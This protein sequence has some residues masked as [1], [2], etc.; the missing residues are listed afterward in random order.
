MTSMLAAN[1]APS[2]ESMFAEL[3]ELEPDSPEF[4]RGRDRIIEHTLSIADHVARRFDGRGEL[5]DDLV[6]V[7]RVGLINAVIRFDVRAGSDFV[8]FAVPTITG[9]IRHHFRDRSWSVKVPRRYK[10]LYPRLDAATSVL[11]QR[12]GR[13]PT[14]SEVADE[15]GLDRAEVVEGLV[16]VSAY[17]ILSIDGA[18]D[19]E[20][21]MAIR[22]FGESD[23]NLDGIE[24]R[25][26]LRT[27][28]ATLPDRERTVLVLR[29]F[30]SLSQSQIADRIG[31]SQMQVSRLL[32][33]SLGQLRDQVA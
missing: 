20:V 15:L 21:P 6:Q 16:A 23:P 22:G 29:F 18:A 17:N 32:A 24:N 27:L 11:S 5:R 13:A 30:G 7:A 25:E 3:A 10:E 2:I 19:G 12:L 28:L 33:K 14:A 4:R 31:V 9:E 8:S 26:A 1:A